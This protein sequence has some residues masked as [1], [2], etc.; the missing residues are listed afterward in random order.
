MMEEVEVD[1]MERGSRFII[2]IFIML[3]LGGEFVCEFEI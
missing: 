2:R 3:L 1:E